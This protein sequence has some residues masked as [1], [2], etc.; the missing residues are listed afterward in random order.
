M[1]AIQETPAQLEKLRAN[2]VQLQEERPKIEKASVPRDEALDLIERTISHNA[3]RVTPMYGVLL[4][5]GEN[6][7]ALDLVPNGH[8]AAALC[9]FLPNLVRNKL[10]AEVDRQL[11]ERPSGLPTAER[12][13][14][15]AKIDAAIRKLG[16]EE[17]QIITE[18]EAAGI[19]LARRGDADPRIVLSVVEET[20][21]E[22]PKPPAKRPKVKKSKRRWAEADLG[23]GR[24]KPIQNTRPTRI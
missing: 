18:A 16:V 7:A 12:P 24:A 2:I 17:E 8:V 9:S 19:D 4:R 14:A 6:A 3:S 10:I 13:A 1:R 22:P 15:L 23:T 20:S 5:P 21:S 11:E